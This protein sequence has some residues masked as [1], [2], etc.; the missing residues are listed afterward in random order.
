MA[1]DRSLFELDN[2]L[3]FI[4]DKAIVAIRVDH[5][6][7]ILERIPDAPEGSYCQVR[8]EVEVDLHQSVQRDQSIVKAWH[9]RQ[10]T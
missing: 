5:R 1:V 3:I 10:K 6:L 2:F 7:A 8:R 9:E 4:H